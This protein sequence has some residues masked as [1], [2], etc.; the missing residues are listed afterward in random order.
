METVANILRTGIFGLKHSDRGDDVM[1]M[2]V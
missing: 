2:M 1:A